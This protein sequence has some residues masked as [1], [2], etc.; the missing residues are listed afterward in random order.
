MPVQSSP[1]QSS[2]VQSSPVRDSCLSWLKHSAAKLIR[3]DTKFF[4]F[5][6]KI[7]GRNV[8]TYK[9]HY[10]MS[11]RTDHYSNA[12][13][14]AKHFIFRKITSEN[15]HT[16]SGADFSVK[17]M[18]NYLANLSGLAEGFGLWTENNEPAGHVWI[19]YKGGTR[20]QFHLKTIDAL[21][22][23]VFVSERFRRQG[24]CEYMFREV[25]R[26]LHGQ[27]GIDKVYLAVRRGNYPARQAYK[28]FGGIE[29][30][31]LK[32]FRFFKI[33]FPIHGFD[34]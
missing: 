3:I 8:F 13:E 26:Y 24:L 28:K 25:F 10:I 19:M 1:V 34:L 20:L 4:P 11:F 5:A 16:F 33:A 30:R 27:R 6:V 23:D 14:P 7:F 32:H 31:S 18:E 15:L 17:S 12:P 22:F 29:E 9:H 21:L 2:P